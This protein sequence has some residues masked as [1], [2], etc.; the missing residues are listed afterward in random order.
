M[1]PKSNPKISKSEK[2]QMEENLSSSS[3]A[4]EEARESAPTA[5][6]FECI[7]CHKTFT[8][9]SALTMHKVRVHTRKGILSAR[10]GALASVRAKHRKKLSEAMRRSWALRKQSGKLRRGRQTK[11]QV[12][13]AR[14]EHQRQVR[15]AWYAQGLNSH[16]EPYKKGSG[17]RRRRTVSL[18]AL[19]DRTKAQPRPSVSRGRAKARNYQRLYYWKKRA[20]QGHQVPPDIAQQLAN[21]TQPEIP[22]LGPPAKQ[23]APA[24][25]VMF[26]P[27]CGT[28]I[29]NVQT[30]VNFGETT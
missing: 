3:T 4:T 6:T 28:N 19:A 18:D 16:G 23:Q 22:S 12:L 30:A 27:V 21:G 11:E 26:C 10:A 15:A 5:E 17:P 29:H 7:Q 13:A 25:A 14:R 8:S 9:R 2:H 1:L 24:R 20:E